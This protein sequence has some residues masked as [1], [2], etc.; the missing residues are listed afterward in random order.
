[1]DIGLSGTQKHNMIAYI[2]TTF[3][4]NPKI[5]N[6]SYN[7]SSTNTKMSPRKHTK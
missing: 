6:S 4:S 2:Q 3:R 1:M 7:Y 5:G